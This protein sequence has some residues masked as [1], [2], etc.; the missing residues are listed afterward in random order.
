MTA[1]KTRVIAVVGP[2]AVGKTA[3]AEELAVR[4]DGEI[5]NADSMQIYRGMD[6]GT[7][8]PPESERRVP[9]RCLDIVDPGAPYSAAL[10]QRDAREAIAGIASRG[11]TAVVVGGTGLYLRA[12]LD[13]MSFPRGE[14]VGNPTRERYEAYEAANGPRALHALLAERD[15]QSA[16][17]IHPNNVRRVVRALEL[18]DE[19]TTYAEQS[20]GFG[21]RSAHYA[22]T[23]WIG[24]A[25]NRQALYDRIDARVDAMIDKGL[26][27]EVRLLLDSGFRDALTA[28][29][30]IGY[31]ELVGVIERHER[32][33]DAV[34]AI[35]QASRR[36]AKRQLTW[37]R[38][39]PR[40]RWL[41]V[42][43][44]SLSA[45]ADAALKLID[46]DGP[47]GEGGASELA[48]PAD[49][50]LEG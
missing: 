45:A 15:P 37:F 26:L 13:E 28:G 19:G 18:L 36:Y 21:D 39:D 6:I 25:M 22:D 46:S 5:V 29:Q 16:A 33:E 49:A 43:D 1:P 17:L 7:A 35:K 20:A 4:L 50:D 48:A 38:A 47:L 30:A 24:L 23:A 34:A 8:K 12:A 44:L 2:T 42:T 40:V 14:Q 31:K 41:D 32:L 3:L 27:D 10:F 9:Y 11:R